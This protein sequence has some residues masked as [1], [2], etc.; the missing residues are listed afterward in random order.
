MQTDQQNTHQLLEEVRQG[1]RHAYAWGIGYTFEAC[2][3]LHGIPLQAAIHT[4]PELIGKVQHGLPLIAP[5]DLL[6][7]APE[8]T[9]IIGYSSTFRAQIAEYCRRIPSVPVIFYDDPSILSRNRILE[10][11][12]SLKLAA[13]SGI[14]HP[15]TL[16]LIHQA[17]ANPS[18]SAAE[19]TNEQSYSYLSEFVSDVRRALTKQVHFI[20]YENI[21]GDIAEFGTCSGTTASCLASAMAG[22]FYSLRGKIEN[23][24]EQ[25]RK[26]HLFDSFK[27]LPA[28]TNELDIRAGWKEGS[29]KDKSEA[30][31]NAMVQQYLPAD[32]VRTYAGWFKDTL[33]SL[34]AGQKF[35]LVHVDC[36]I[37]ESTIDV[38]DYLFANNHISDG[39]TIFFD[40]WNC[41]A[42]SPDL[43]ERRAWNEMVKKY[44]I[45]FTDCGNYSAYGNKFIIHSASHA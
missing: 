2:R 37:Y 29:Y 31:L 39:G 7:L 30:E 9:L 26:L 40:D 11:L 10:I 28:I 23:V 22:A 15:F 6:K 41:G 8:T 18:G 44:R 42:A 14:V 16:Q 17:T 27:G 43:G 38:L 36:D 5:E 3:L 24:E 21:P 35:S 33:K 45:N 20:H 12:S 25:P 32:S 13:E 19:G 4:A 34:A 1:A